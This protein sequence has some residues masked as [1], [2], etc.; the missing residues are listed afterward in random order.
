[1]REL[2]D[3][4]GPPPRAVENLLEYAGIK[5]A[6][7]KLRIESVERRQETVTVRFHPRTPVSPPRLVEF[8]RRVEGAG[9]DPGGTL[10][11]PLARW[12]GLR[13]L[14]DLRKRLLALRG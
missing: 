9:I 2:E 3:R 1:M 8:V 11:F 10:H 5:A 6:A 13:W 14:A 12:S 4:F 7:E